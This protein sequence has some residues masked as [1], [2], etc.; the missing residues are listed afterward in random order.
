MYYRPGPRASR[1][2]VTHPLAKG[3]QTCKT[4]SMIKGNEMEVYAVAAGEDYH[5]EDMDTL[6]LFDCKSAAEAYAKEL[7]DQFGVDYV[8]MKVLPVL[9]H[10]A[11]AA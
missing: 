8:E 6:K 10:S 1:Q 3:R 11:L 2:S 9:M 4:N 7:E 5:G